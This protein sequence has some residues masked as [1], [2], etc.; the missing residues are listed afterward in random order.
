MLVAVAVNLVVVAYESHEGERLASE[1]LIADATQARGDVWSSI[2]VIAALAGARSG[3]PILDPIGAIVVACFIAYSGYQIARSTTRILS[4]RI[5]IAE[6]EIEAVVL[7]VPG[8]LGC[9]QIRS[10]GTSDHAFLDLHVWLAPDMP[11]T[12][13]HR[14]SHVVKD[15]LMHRY[16]QIV[17]AVIHMEPPPG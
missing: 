15:R 16:P 2:A 3:L 4:D 7:S 8:V 13:A 14:L 9:H 6:S 12:E 1:V 11:L 10:R 17:D 5:V